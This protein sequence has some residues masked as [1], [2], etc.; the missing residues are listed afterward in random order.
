MVPNFAQSPPLLSSSLHSLADAFGPQ[1]P[2]HVE[3]LLRVRQPIPL[4]Q[5]RCDFLSMDEIQGIDM[6]R[7]MPMRAHRIDI[8]QQVTV[9]DTV[10]E[11]SLGVFITE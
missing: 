2:I 11:L 9:R 5:K 1:Y 10:L 6:C 8:P 4:R 3:P 7:T